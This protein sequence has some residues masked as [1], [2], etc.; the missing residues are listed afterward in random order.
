MTRTTSTVMVSFLALAGGLGWTLAP[1]MQ[2]QAPSD[3]AW[4]TSLPDGQPDVQG[5]WQSVGPEGASGLNIEPLDNMMNTGTT[6]PGIVIDPPDGLIPYLP[7]AR[8]RRDEVLDEHLTPNPAQV[9]TRTRGWPDGVPRIN[10]YNVN[11]YQIVQP[12]GAVVILYETQHEFRY[13]PLDGRPQPDDGV[14]LWMGS[15]RGRWEDTTLIVE[16]S[17]VSDRVRMSVVGDFHSDEVQI[18]ERWHFVDAN[19]IEHTATIDDPNVY[20]RPWTMAQTIKRITYPG[21]EL[22]EYSG[23]EGD[24]DAHLMVHIGENAEEDE[25]EKE[26]E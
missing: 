18:T 9:D 25:E 13:I 22:M 26:E 20:S 16:V 17:N 2:A 19:T 15:S 21:F 12:S 8:V 24:K 10:Y 1:S 14:K 11:P 23:V 7:W 5:Y 6:A 3:A 4:P